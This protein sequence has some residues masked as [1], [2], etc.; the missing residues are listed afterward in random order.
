LK[1]L[2]KYTLKRST[3]ASEG[4]HWQRNLKKVTEKNGHKGS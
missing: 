1:F 4:V 2:L 3:R